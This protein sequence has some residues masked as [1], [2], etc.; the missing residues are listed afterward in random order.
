MG[1]IPKL[2]IFISLIFRVNIIFLHFLKENLNEI[3]RILPK[4]ANCPNRGI[5]QHSCTDVCIKKFGLK[6]FQP[7]P[8]LEKRRLRMLKIYPLPTNWIEVPD[9]AT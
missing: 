9:I 1:V 8:V 4:V 2:I 3:E 7:H 6:K 5:T